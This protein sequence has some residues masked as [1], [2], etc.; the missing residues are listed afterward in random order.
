[1]YSVESAWETWACMYRLPLLP[2]IYISNPGSVLTPWSVSQFAKTWVSLQ[3]TTY[4]SKR[5]KYF[6]I[7]LLHTCKEVLHAPIAQI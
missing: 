5:T 3:T 7:L 4:I 1:M 2:S 6:D